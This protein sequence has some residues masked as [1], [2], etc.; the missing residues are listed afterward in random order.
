MLPAWYTPLAVEEE[1][2]PAMVPPVA[3]IIVEGNEL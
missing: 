2:R 3:K 1:P